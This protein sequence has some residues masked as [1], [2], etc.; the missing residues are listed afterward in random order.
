VIS[1]AKRQNDYPGYRNGAPE[2]TVYISSLPV[3]IGA[4]MIAAAIL[5]STLV[6]A[7]GTRYIGIDGPT[8]DTAWLIDRLTGSVYRC[9]ASVRGKASCETEIATGSVAEHTKQPDQPTK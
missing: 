1:S 4:A 6:N 2:R 9:Q 3:L 7:L 8:E 5:L